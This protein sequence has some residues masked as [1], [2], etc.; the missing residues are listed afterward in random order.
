M[1]DDSPGLALA[2]DVGQID[3]EESLRPM[4]AARRP[5][6]ALQAPRVRVLLAGLGH[7]VIGRLEVGGLSA[8]DDVA[9]AGEELAMPADWLGIQVQ[10][11]RNRMIHRGG[12]GGEAPGAGGRPRN[13]RV[14]RGGRYTR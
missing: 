14:R 3:G 10:R 7:Q 5:E 1:R 4:V 11:K 13:A 6:M 12:T 8:E 2:H 9:D